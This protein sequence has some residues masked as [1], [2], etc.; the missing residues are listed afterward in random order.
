MQFVIKCKYIFPVII[1]NYSLLCETKLE[2]RSI[3]LR[4]NS[5]CFLLCLS[6]KL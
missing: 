3:D 1:A 6:T 2:A 4:K 5:A